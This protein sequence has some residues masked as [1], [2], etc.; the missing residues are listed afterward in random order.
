MTHI[1]NPIIWAD[2]PDI[3][4]I[5]IDKT[6]YMVSTSMHSMPGCPIMRSYDLKHWEI[7]SYVFDRLAEK[8]G[9]NLENGKNI[10]GKGSWAA[11]LRYANGYYYCLF[12]SNDDG[13]AYI[14]RT[15]DIESSNWEK[16]PLKCSL[17]DPGILVDDGKSYVIYSNGDIR[18]V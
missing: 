4:V 17:H 8:E 18:I 9:N 6:F 2:V 3:D 15:K 14:F 5:R 10:Y 13:H 1:H 16:Y 7:V 12:N 11:S